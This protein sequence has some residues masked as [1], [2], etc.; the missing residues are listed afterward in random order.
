MLEYSGVQHNQVIHFVYMRTR[1]TANIRKFKSYTFPSPPKS[2]QNSADKINAPEFSEPGFTFTANK[3][4]EYIIRTA[5]ALSQHILLINLNDL[6][7]T[8]NFYCKVTHM[9]QVFFKHGFLRSFSVNTLCIPR[10]LGDWIRDEFGAVFF[11]IVPIS[12]Q[13]SS[14]G[15]QSY[16]QNGGKPD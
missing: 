9:L 14:Y 10:N 15:V 8:S 13:M 3:R 5:Q 4:Y 12:S 6:T 2:P 1:Y 16:G 7:T 11:L